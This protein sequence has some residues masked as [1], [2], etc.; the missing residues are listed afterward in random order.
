MGK[1]SSQTTGFR[2][3]MSLH[4][5]LGRGPV[6]ELVE[7]RVGDQTA[8]AGSQ[9][10]GSFPINAPQL[11]GGEAKEG[12]IVGTFRLFMGAKDQVYDPDVKDS[13]AQAGGLVPDF[14]GIVTAWFDGQVC[15][16]NPYPKEWKFR[17]RRSKKGWQNDVCWYPEKAVIS[18]ADGAIKAANPAHIIYECAT[19]SEWGRGL[20]RAMI[21]D[22]VWRRVAD[23]LYAEGMGLCMQWT[24]QDSLDAFVQNVIDHIGGAIFVNRSTG[25][26]DLALIRGDYS[27]LDFSNGDLPSYDLTTGLLGLESD[28]GSSADQSYNEIVVKY[29]DPIT[30]S[31]GQVRAQNI[32]AFQAT[33]AFVST[34]KDFSGLPT[35]DLAGRVALRELNVS[36]SNL[37]R[38][39]V[40]LDRRAWATA[41]A[42][43]MRVTYKGLT[44]VLRVVTIDDGSF[45]EG[46][47]TVTA[48]QDVFGL[49]AT[50]FVT[51]QETTWKRPDPT[52]KPVPAQALVELT[53][54]DLVKE[55]SRADLAQITA[56][57]CY[58]GMVASRPAGLAQNYTLETAA[59]GETLADRNS[60]NWTPTA[61]LKAALGPYDTAVS[62]ENA[63]DLNA[64]LLGEV[65]LV[66][67][68]ICRV[69]MLDQ[70]A[71]TM[72][73]A[74][75]C[76][77]T[78][79]AKHALGARLWWF[80]DDL[81]PD[82]R[83]YAEGET[84]SAVALTKTSSDTLAVADAPVSAVVTAARQGRPYPP[85]AVA[86]N[87][88]PIFNLGDT[89]TPG[90]L[91][92][93]WSHRDRVLEQ[94]QLVEHGADSVGPEAGTT[95][96]V[97]TYDGDTLKSTFADIDATTWTYT[98]A[99]AGADGDLPV[100]TFR[101]TSVRDG[102]ESLQPYAVTVSRSASG[103][104]EGYGLTYGGV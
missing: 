25:L 89:I 16:N 9:S 11:F 2:Y 44:T 73:L 61:T 93:T 78:I 96:T 43:V 28:D 39:K 81:T 84:V 65:V 76:V 86:V 57:E 75:G 60:G 47:I 3:L 54:R 46:K 30:N 62:F 27:D 88:T 19:N 101:L 29:H 13:L 4:M 50:S 55:L 85:G 51:P 77:D 41:P 33:S 40:Y 18:L 42:S 87:G 35:K 102:L 82:G 37:K 56:D 69:D 26:L 52:A 23:T 94:D 98:G 64:D 68:E 31:D 24:R 97:R 15:A 48:L 104:G 63:K 70:E 12:G 10:G 20:D 34:T 92:F 22:A 21:N 8:Y 36:A 74:R 58:V 90:D 71:G 32:A 91:V 14:R 38:Y 59:T 67:D 83:H 100:V 45:T 99:L 80:D 49:P 95:Y 66:D 6:D 17:L 1:G 79:P 7:I 5:G 72:T 53:Y 103:Y